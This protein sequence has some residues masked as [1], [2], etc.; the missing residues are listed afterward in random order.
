[1]NEYR[2]RILPVVRMSLAA[3]AFGLGAFGPAAAQTE[4]QSAPPAPPSYATPSGEEQI[5]GTISAVTGKYTL[6]LRD[7]RG[8]MDNVTLHPGTIINPTGLKLLAGMPVTIAG[9]NAGA[10]FTANEIDA[11]YT[12]ALVT[13]P[14]GIGFGAGWGWGPRYRAGFWW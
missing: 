4:L 10:S 9:H 3:V 14:I 12:M 7:S 6:Q 13:A 2:R 5:R 8:F 1:M 11:P